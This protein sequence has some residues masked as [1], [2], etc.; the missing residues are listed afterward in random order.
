MESINR[1]ILSQIDILS[2]A[3]LASPIE[4]N[5]KFK[6]DEIELGD[7]LLHLKRLRYIRVEKNGCAPDK[8]LPNGI[9]AVCITDDGRQFLKKL[10]YI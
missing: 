9:C 2:R 1:K 10:K 7:R 5:K 8:S 6:L 4:V 3:S